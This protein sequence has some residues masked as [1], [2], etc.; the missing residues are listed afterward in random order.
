M[1]QFFV[2]GIPKAKQSPRAVT[3]V[4][5]KEGY[6]QLD[7]PY[8]YAAT[9]KVWQ[10][11]VWMEAKLRAPEAPLDGPLSLDLV[12]HM[13]KPKSAKRNKYWCDKR[14]DLDNLVKAIKDVLKGLLYRD[15]SQIVSL[16]ADKAYSPSPGVYIEI[17]P[18]PKEIIQNADRV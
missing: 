15:D 17:L 5:T 14:P 1:I 7:R 13:P 8:M 12:F 16:K 10:T 9:D 18:L 6:R 2:P 3:R 4:R 11:L